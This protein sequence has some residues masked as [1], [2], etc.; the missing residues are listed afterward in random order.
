MYNNKYDQLYKYLKLLRCNYNLEKDNAKRNVLLSD[1]YQISSFLEEL[2]YPVR[3]LKIKEEK[4]VIKYYDS[5]IRLIIDDVLKNKDYLLELLNKVKNELSDKFDLS[6]YEYNKQYSLKY[7]KDIVLNYYN[8]YNSDYNEIVK[9]SMEKLII[10]K[11]LKL[12]LYGGASALYI[13]SLNKSIIIVGNYDSSIDLIINLIHEIGHIINCTYERENIYNNIFD[14]AFSISMEFIAKDYLYKQKII[15]N[16]DFNNE[17]VELLNYVSDCINS[18]ANL[19]N[20]E[21][22][23]NN[24]NNTIDNLKYFIGYIVAINYY[25][26][27]KEDVKIKEEINKFITSNRKLD[28]IH[29]LN[30]YGLNKDALIKNIKLCLKDK[31]YNK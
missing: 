17:I 4:V 6:D 10:E 31:K 18:L 3:K 8:N 19:N 30:S 7:I 21:Y 25:Y 9:Q 20:I 15:S 13:E 5:Y 2:S 12:C 22:I 26:L 28:I 11:N 29:M 24:I 1:I 27:Y 16:F 23:N 14:E